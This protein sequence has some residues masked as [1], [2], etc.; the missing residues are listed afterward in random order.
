MEG[1]IL[2][3]IGWVL[4]NP[5]IYDF[6]TLWLNRSIGVRED[7]KSFWVSLFVSELALQ[8]D[9]IPSFKSSEIAAA[10]IVIARYSLYERVVWPEALER[11]SGYSWSDLQRPLLTLSSMLEARET[12]HKLKIIHRRYRKVDRMEASLVA[13]RRIRCTDQLE[14]MGRII[15]RP[16]RG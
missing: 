11:D 9:I 13:I 2:H 10:V 1:K 16:P 5:T 14:R 12:F 4:S 7:A 8:T 15:D 6:V 3:R